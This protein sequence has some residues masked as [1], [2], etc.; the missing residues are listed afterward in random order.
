MKK[1]EEEMRKEYD[2]S[3]GVRGKHDGQRLLMVGARRR[4]TSRNAKLAS[5]IQKAIESDIQSREGFDDLWSTLDDKQ[6]EEIRSAWQDRIDDL[7]D[8]AGREHAEPRS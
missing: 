1:T 7:L 8:K 5:K 4:R 3:K 2:F 6:R